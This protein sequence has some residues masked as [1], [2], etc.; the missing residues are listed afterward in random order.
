MQKLLNISL[1]YS[2][3]EKHVHT[4]Y[5]ANAF[6]WAEEGTW[7]IQSLSVLLQSSSLN[8]SWQKSSPAAVEVP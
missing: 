8:S 6:P 5:K 2:G 7:L 4:K 3:G 1:Q